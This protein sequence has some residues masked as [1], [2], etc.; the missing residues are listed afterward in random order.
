M[1]GWGDGAWGWG[2]RVGDGGWG[3][4]MGLGDGAWGWGLDE[5]AAVHG[6]STGGFKRKP[7]M[8]LGIFQPRLITG[9]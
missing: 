5:M 1:G 3:L 4:G 7:S 8:K 2:M 9:G 6:K